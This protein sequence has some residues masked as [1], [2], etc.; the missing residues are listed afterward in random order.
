MISQKSSIYEMKVQNYIQIPYKLDVW[1]DQH[2]ALPL[3]VQIIQLY[4][5]KNLL[6]VPTR[7]SL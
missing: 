6:S 3:S 5:Y 1:F 7:Y 4:S 2:C